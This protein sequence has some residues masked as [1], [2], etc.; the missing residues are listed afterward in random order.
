MRLE[1]LNSPRPASFKNNITYNTVIVKYA[2]RIVNIDA[3][4]W[5]IRFLKSNVIILIV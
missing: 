3:L 4:L 1:N 2:Y 5:T